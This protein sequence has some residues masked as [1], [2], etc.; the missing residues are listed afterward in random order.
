MHRETG[1][2]LGKKALGNA[3]GRQGV[4]EG[5][6]FHSDRGSQYASKGYEKMLKENGIKGSMSRPGCPYDNSCME[7]FFATL[8]KERVYRRNYDIMEE[9]RQ[10][11][12]RYIRIIL[13]Q[14]TSAF[15]I[16][17]YESGRIQT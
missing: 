9:I 11:M 15:G 6:L 2:S 16:R 17:I 5:L 1:V 13:Q 14:K 7:S 12:F 3:I 4:K 8:K 10:D